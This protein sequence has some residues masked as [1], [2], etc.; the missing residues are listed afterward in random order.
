MFITKA[1]LFDKMQ[2]ILEGTKCLSLVELNYVY[3][4]FLK[5]ALP[6]KEKPNLSDN[7]DLKIKIY[8]Y[9]FA[10]SILAA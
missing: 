1:V 4:K 10:R 9:R 2:Y 3:N 5:Y 6:Q 8:D 7:R